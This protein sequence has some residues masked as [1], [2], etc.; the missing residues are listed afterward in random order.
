M[1]RTILLDA[2]IVAYKV[3]CTNQKDYDFGDT[4]KARVLDHET[5][6]RQTEELIATYCEATKAARVVVCLS[7]KENFRKTVDGTYK[8]NRKGLEKPEMLDWVKEYLAEE[9]P[10]YVRPGL[11]ADD[12]MGILSMR[13]G[14]LGKRYANDQVIMVSEDKDMRT[15]PS[16]LYNPN[17]P[18]L[19]VISI[20]EEDAIRFHM[21]QV[22]TGDQTDG[23]PGCRGIGAKSDYVSYLMEDATRDEFWDVVCEAYASKGY[24]E[25]DAILQ[26]RL[27]HILWD[28]SYDFKAKEVILWEPYWI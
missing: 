6:L 16:L 8:S 13:P 27:A 19:G 17:Q 21:W 9:Y 15:I 14:L 25:E 24:T 3:A 11:E 28:T 10:S 12:V 2:D 4:G 23:Y 22:L 7:S 1:N 5:C 18:Q 26:A 20:S